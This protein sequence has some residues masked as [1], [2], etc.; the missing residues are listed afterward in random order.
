MLHL[1]NYYYRLKWN[2]KKIDNWQRKSHLIFKKEN[3]LL[4]WINDFLNLGN[5]YFYTYS[6][7]STIKY[8]NLVL[9]IKMIIFNLFSFFYY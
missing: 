9:N 2:N 5:W 3:V 6:K 1:F 7:D 8:D 4:D